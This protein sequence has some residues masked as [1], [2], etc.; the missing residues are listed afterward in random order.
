MTTKRFVPRS[1]IAYFALLAATILLGARYVSERSQ[2][3]DLAAVKRD[4]L[5]AVGKRIT[6]PLLDIYNRPIKIQDKMLVLVMPP[7]GGCTKEN[8]LPIAQKIKAHW[9]PEVVLVFPNK[10]AEITESYKT[11][12]AFKLVSDTSYE[13]IPSRWSVYAPFAIQLDGAQTVTQEFPDIES[14]WSYVKSG[15]K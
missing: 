12:A 10:K 3:P 9:A 6:L 2:V 14:V 13:V 1:I 7:C 4:A 8:L 11:S 15:Q 5:M